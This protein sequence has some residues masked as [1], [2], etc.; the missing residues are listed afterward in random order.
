[1]YYRPNWFLD[2]YTMPLVY[3][4]QFADAFQFYAKH[5]MSGTDFDTLQGQWATQGPNLYLLARIHQRPDTPV[6][7]LL[8]EYYQAFGPAADTVKEYWNYWE[9]Y[10]IKNSPH[11]ADAIRSRHDGLFRRYAH[12]A[13]VADELYPA[14]C[15]APAMK[16]LDRALEKTSGGDAT[17]IFKERVTFLRDGLRYAE[18]CSATAAVVNNHETSLADKRAAIAKL[19]ELRRSLEHTNIANMDRGGIIETDSWKDVQGLF[20]P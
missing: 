19:V 5:G 17:T 2:G 15:F 9:N 13:Q 16:I 14:P 10:A 7:D 20:G 11:A 18:G 12:Y 4:H 8:D 3:M 1:M 6:D